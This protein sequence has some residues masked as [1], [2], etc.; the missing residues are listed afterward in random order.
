M[1]CDGPAQSDVAARHA[2]AHPSP[3]SPTLPAEC[4]C[5][6]RPACQP[7]RGTHPAP[8]PSHAAVCC[9]AAFCSCCV[10][11]HLRKRQLRG[12]MS[13][14]IWCGRGGCESLMQ[15]CVC[16]QVVFPTGSETQ[17]AALLPLLQLQWRLAVLRPLRRAVLSPAV[18]VPGGGLSWRLH[19]SC[20]HSLLCV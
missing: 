8:H 2:A 4:L 14:Y 12:D 19:A 1:S 13:R 15:S 20:C 3:C 16:S 17:P 5:T 11:Y 9:V 10:S 18:P 6:C 7:H